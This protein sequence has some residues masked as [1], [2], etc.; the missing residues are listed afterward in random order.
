M[1]QLSIKEELGK[2]NR[3]NLETMAAAA[4]EVLE[5][6]RVLGKTGNNV[7][8][9][10]LPHNDTFRQFDHCPAGDVYDQDSFSQ[11][12]YHAHREGEH[13][14]FHT[15]MRERGMPKGVRPVAQSETP[16]MKN[17]DDKL[18]HVV[19]IS[20]DARGRPIGLF[21]TNRWV[22]SE[23]W[24]P[25]DDVCAMLDRFEIDH[26]WPSWPTNRWVSAMLRLFRPQIQHL[27]QERDGVVTSWQ[28][29][30]PEVDVFE[31]RR[32]DLPSQ[33]KISL[34][35]Q[36]HHIA[37]ALD[38]RGC[39]PGSGLQRDRFPIPDGAFRHQKLGIETRP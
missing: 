1:R 30:H 11:Y 2:L 37:A 15:F 31:D 39:K 5:W 10:V 32:L 18:S 38:A 14:H 7:V 13:G 20:M 22:T 6:H 4:C 8:A 3:E 21:T 9:E 28:N 36:I 24:Y 17:R 29:E 12:Y 33:A 26:T 19:A 16:N 27:L 25:A 35:R 23:N 34:D